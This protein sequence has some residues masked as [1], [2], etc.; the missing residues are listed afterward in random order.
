M[1]RS[2]FLRQIG[3][4][5]LE[6]GSVRWRV[7]AP[8]AY[9]VDLVLYTAAGGQE[10]I[11][12]SAEEHGYFSVSLANISEGQAYAYRLD[13]Q[14]TYPDP[15]SLWQPWGVH[16]PSAVVRTERF[17]WT[18]QNWRGVSCTNLAIYELH[19]GTFTES[20]KLD[21]I[22]DRLPDLVDLG[23]T[24]IELMP[25]A[26]FP[27]E[28]NWGYDGVH[29]YAVQNSY[30]GPWALARL[31]DACHAHGLAVILDVVYNHLGPEGNYLERFG[32][33]FTDRYR[34]P[35][36][37][38]FN[39]DGPD[40]DGVRQFVCDN[41][42]LWL[43]EYHL[44]GLRLDAVHAIYDMTA[45][46]ILT[47]IRRVAEEAAAR[48]GWPAL[49]IA[50][51]NL[52]DP[53]LVREECLGGYGLHAV[54]NDDYHHALHAYYT[55]E[56]Q[57]YCVDF[58]KPEHIV[59]AWRETYVL[60]GIYSHYRRR[61]HGA[62]VGDVSGERF[63]V[64]LQN[65]D[66]V[67]NRARAERLIQLL[68]P[69]VYRQ[70]ICLV[71][72]APYI[73]LLF[74]GEEYGEDRPFYFFTSFEDRRLAE[75]IREGRRKE[76]AR[77]GWVAEVPDPQAV[78]TFL[79][80]KISWRW[81]EIK[82]RAQLRQLYKDLLQCRKVWPAWR[83]FTSRDA[84][85]VPSAHPQ[86]LQLWRGPRQGVSTRIVCNLTH[87]PQ[88][89]PVGQKNEAVLLSSEWP[90]YGGARAPDSDYTILLPWECLILGPSEWRW[91]ETHQT[92]SS[93]GDSNQPDGES[94]G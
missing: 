69:P 11:P 41:V 84:E 89:C 12:M 42:R 82:G 67:A 44:D 50:E 4:H 18:D 74:M 27:G 57:A 59:K 72:A 78:E 92:E 80:S 15:A 46:H 26:Q 37:P 90:R 62:P 88:P 31:V 56:R 77:L 68:P 34:T 75:Q 58:G 65:H 49:V 6:D 52:N 9:H 43:E 73:P 40:S 29:L 45:Q 14:G 47:D 33:Y 86:V 60:D 53:R 39:Y 63:I 94:G 85:L 81:S 7:W 28:R 91:L 70:A 16:N 64:Y 22:I 3:P 55:G 79:A 48:R 13:D 93:P 38:A 61:R 25:V 76:L 8:N 51:S 36:G 19:C 1:G 24:A 21:A 5:A 71:L 20:G 2:Q 66:L 32:P 87:Q 10:I 83:D 54:W 35:W 17:S 23:V 30:G